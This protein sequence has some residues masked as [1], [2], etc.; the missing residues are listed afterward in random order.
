MSIDLA[1]PRCRAMTHRRTRCRRRTT[2]I[3]FRDEWSLDRLNTSPD[4]PVCKLH[5]DKMR[6]TRR[7]PE[8]W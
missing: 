6:R 5:W 2:V 7:R 4:M 3:V 8:W 1:D